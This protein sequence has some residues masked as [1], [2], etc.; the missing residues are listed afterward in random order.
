[1]TNRIFFTVRTSV[2]LLLSLIVLHCA[3]PAIA[4]GSDV[5]EA[6][7]LLEAMHRLT[8]TFNFDAA[9]CDEAVPLLSASIALW[10]KM[11]ETERR[12][13]YEQLQLGLCLLAAEDAAGAAA[14]FQHILDKP[15]DYRNAKIVDGARLKLAD[16][17]AEGRGVAL[18]RVRALGLYLLTQPTDWDDRRHRDRAA[19]ELIYELSGRTSELFYALLER[20]VA[21]NWRLA[22]T[23]RI[24]RREYGLGPLRMGIRALSSGI[25]REGDERE[26]SAV[27]SISFDVGRGL[28]D[29]GNGGHLPAALIYLQRA[30]ANEAAPLLESI[31]KKLPYRLLMPDG[32]PWSAAHVQP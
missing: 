23:M 10:E 6:T 4:Q 22:L 1:M 24:E 12:D 3:S 8:K 17:Y 2:R 15:F 16:L 7:R 5:V 29:S 25:G 26:L 20:D 27:R 18:D 21:S 11:P 32:K 30:Q 14:R 9:V 19:A 28:L 31:E 13:D